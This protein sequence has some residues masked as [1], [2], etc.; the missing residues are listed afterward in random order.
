MKIGMYGRNRWTTV[1]RPRSQSSDDKRLTD[2]E[3][4]EDKT[5]L[6][7][8]VRQLV[9]H[10]VKADVSV[11]VESAHSWRLVVLVQLKNASRDVNENGLSF[12]YKIKR[13]TVHTYLRS[14][15]HGGHDFQFS[16]FARPSARVDYEIVIERRAVSIYDV[17]L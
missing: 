5:V 17:P 16:P 3:D 6:G 13:K 15:R 12:D 1:Q 2:A 11:Q 8:L 14:V 7:R 4:I 10:T 9:G